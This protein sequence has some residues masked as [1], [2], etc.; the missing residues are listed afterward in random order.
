MSLTPE[1][2]LLAARTPG[3]PLPRLGLLCAVLLSSAATPMPAVSAGLWA[4]GVVLLVAHGVR[5]TRLKLLAV[6]LAWTAGLGALAA[7]ASSNPTALL[8]PLLRVCTALTWCVW[9]GATTSWPSLRTALRRAGAPMALMDGV[10]GMV[11]HGLLLLRTLAARR[12][13]AVLRQGLGPGQPYLHMLDTL[14][15]V[16]AGGMELAYARSVRLEEASTVRSAPQGAEPRPQAPVAELRGA[17]VHTGNGP[18]RLAGVELSLRQGEWVALAGP[19]GSGKSTLLRVVAGLEPLSSGE[20]WRFG[21]RV[22]PGGLAARVEGRVGLVWQEPDD[23]LFGTTPLDDL[24]WGLMRRGVPEPEACER[25]RRMLEAL[26]VGALAERPV[27]ALSFGERKRVACAAALVCEPELLL[28]DE[29]TAGLDPVAARGL[30]R[31]LEH[32]AS[33]RPLTLLWATHDLEHLPARM[34]RVLLL[35]AGLPVFDGE[36]ALAL[37]PVQLARAGLWVPP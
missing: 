16:L 11:A 17:H 19:S 32:V 28:L 27:H 36:R 37:S 21:H 14:G 4:G 33:A 35:H 13:A 26:G 2:A 29:P 34:Q 31:A 22:P 9:F 7:L 1:A 15:R 18:E 20:L 10:D 8:H 3:R 6:G 24:V 12:E 30:V 25:A 23:Q 5:G